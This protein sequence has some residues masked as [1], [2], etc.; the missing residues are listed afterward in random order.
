MQKLKPMLAKIGKKNDLKRKDM[1]YEVKWDGIRAILYKDKKGIRL[2][3]RNGVWIENKYPELQKG[4]AEHINAKNCVLDGEIIVLNAEGI[5]DFQEW[6]NRERSGSKFQI[7]LISERTPAEFIVYDVLYLERKNMMKK[8]LLERKK[9][10]DEIVNDSD[11]ISKSIYT[12]NG[13]KLFNEVRKRNLEGVMAKHINSPYLDGTRSGE[14]LK[15]KFLK[16]ID[17]I[18]IGYR[19]GSGH[20]KNY[21]G[22]LAL[23][24]YRN[25]KLIYIGRVGTGWSDKFV[26]EFFSQM[27]KLEIKKPPAG[28]APPEKGMHWIKPKLICEVEFLEITRDTQLRAPAFKRL[29]EDKTLKECVINIG[30]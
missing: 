8:P 28:N 7:E 23:G 30:I 12:K 22:A 16:T 5:P 19:E 21:F 1:I 15:I 13:T 14:W 18:I 3:S 25:R 10:L 26:K 27:K 24:A 29:R 17:C 6:Q 2:L 9:I 4:L 11:F 20:R